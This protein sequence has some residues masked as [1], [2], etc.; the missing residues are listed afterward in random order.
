MADARIASPPSER[1]KGPILSVLRRTLGL[2]AATTDQEHS[3]LTVLEIACGTGVH[4]AHFCSELGDRVRWTPT[5]YES[6]MFASVEAYLAEAKVSNCKSPRLLDA[7]K[8]DE[9]QVDAQSV[10]LLLNINMIHISP[11]A[12]TEGLIVGA[13]RV[14]KSG[15]VLVTYGPY[16]VDGVISP[17]SNVAFDQSLKSRNPAWGLRDI[18][19]LA[20]LAAEQQ[21]TLEQVIDMPANNKCLVFRK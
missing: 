20:S 8:P 12:A 4:A 1:N 2:E 11:I 5:D 14:L 6:T 10:D 3:P 15:G 18:A 9:W 13:S 7:S 17:D 19:W 21:L 16:M